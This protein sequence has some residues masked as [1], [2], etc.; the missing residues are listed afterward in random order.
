MMGVK[1]ASPVPPVRRS[2]SSAVKILIAEDDPVSA[3]VL[4]RTLEKLGHEPTLAE[5][6]RQALDRFGEFDYRL[7]ISD[8]MMPGLDGIGLCEAIR[9]AANDWY[10]YFILLTARTQREER[11]TALRAGID[12]FLEK[13]LDSAE[14]TARLTVAER[15]LE[16][17]QRLRDANHQLQQKNDEV[18]YLASHDGLTGTLNRRAWFEAATQL[19][20]TAIAVFDIDHFKAVNDQYGHPAG[21]VVLQEVARRVS[22]SVAED[23]VVGRLGGEEFG[24]TFTLSYEDAVEA[25]G[26]LLEAV[27]ESPV[28]LRN[29]TPIPVTVSCGISAWRPGQLSREEAVALTYEAADRALYRAK[30]AGRS[31]VA[32]ASPDER[33]RYAA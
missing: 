21:D 23:G 4:R 18:A 10:T 24:I 11:L 5:D 32:V 27:A 17:E 6:G 22:A 20:P 9:G 14:L 16:W 31:R 1:V 30:A 15:L 13:P 19:R 3:L 12:D 26:A 29:G 8:W 33:E 2:P 25:C 28:V 7:V